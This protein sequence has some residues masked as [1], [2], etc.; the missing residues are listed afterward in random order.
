MMSRTIVTFVGLVLL[1]GNS[2]AF[3]VTPTM[4]ATTGVSTTPEL[5]AKKSVVSK[6]AVSGATG[7]TGR[8]VV[9]E[10]LK[11]DVSV[12]AMVRDE[13]KAKEVFSDPLP[14]GLEVLACDLTS[15][16]AINS[17]VNGC[18]AAIW[19]ATG[20]SDAPG[21]GIVDKLKKL[22]GIALAP[23]QSIDSVGIPALAK[24]FKSAS[25]ETKCPKVVMLSSAGVTR[26][27]WNDEKK[28]R[29]PG[30]AEIPIVRLNPFGIL[31]IKKESEEKLRQS[32]VDYC[33][34]RPAGLNDDWPA[35]SRPVFT[36]GTW[37]LEESTER[38]L[39][40]FSS[41]SC[42][43]PRLQAKPLKPLLLLDILPQCPSTLHS[44][45]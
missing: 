14:K 1:A 13:D 15:E 29:F 17:A 4:A 40:R 8:Y 23:R 42:P 21:D 22:V 7:R 28:A 43:L 10:L 12:V 44:P 27:S 36:Q 30:S 16:D 38:M 20:F 34:V 45:N 3:S 26:P 5:P 32:G 33:I 2:L 41:T 31:D 19:C 18:D 6:V 11:R 35:G 37:Q 9:N 25:K 39:P 24:S